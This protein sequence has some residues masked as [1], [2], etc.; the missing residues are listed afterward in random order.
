MAT[1]IK[2]NSQNETIALLLASAQLLGH[3]ESWIQSH[4]TP[5]GSDQDDYMYIMEWISQCFVLEKVGDVAAV[6][7]ELSPGVPAPPAAASAS[8]PKSGTASAPT[9]M[10]FAAAAKSKAPAAAPPAAVP[11]KVKLLVT[12]NKGKNTTAQNTAFGKAFVK[13]LNEKIQQDGTFYSGATNKA[14]LTKAVDDLMR[15]VVE[16]GWPRVSSK[17]SKVKEAFPTAQ[18]L[19]AVGKVL[20]WWEQK[21]L[22]IEKDFVEQVAPTGAGGKKRTPKEILDIRI[23]TLKS[24]NTKVMSVDPSAQTLNT[25]ELKLALLRDMCNSCKYLLQAFD[26]VMKRNPAPPMPDGVSL[27][28]FKR[29]RRRLWRVLRYSAG[30]Q[31]FLIKGKAILKSRILLEHGNPDTIEFVEPVWVAKDAKLVALFS[32]A[33]PEITIAKDTFINWFKEEFTNTLPDTN[34]KKKSATDSI[35]NFC[36]NPRFNNGIKW[37][38]SLHCEVTLLAYLYLTGTKI[39]GNSIG[40]SKLNCFACSVYTTHLKTASPGIEYNMTGTSGKTHHQWLIPSSA[41]FSTKAALK[42]ASDAGTQKV[43]ADTKAEIRDFLNDTG[44]RNSVGSDSS[45]G[46]G[47]MDANEVYLLGP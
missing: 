37:R 5:T 33:P 24:H 10:N 14:N 46:S 42:T 18:R 20:D 6:A 12:N 11:A 1:Q 13:I 43:K 32:T 4:N 9:K 47:G 8:A 26:G 23:A 3:Q 31:K 7:S 25:T 2:G 30:P 15:V 41:V 22:F 36:N 44:R 34:P 19:T 40:V 21:N 29:L 38:P 28:S 17:L 45:T 27:D 35:T 16:Y 39:I